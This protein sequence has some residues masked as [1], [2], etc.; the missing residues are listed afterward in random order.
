[1]G[2]KCDKQ[3][4]TVSPNGCICHC[5]G[6]PPVAVKP[7]RHALLIG[8]TSDN[9]SLTSVVANDIAGYRDALIKIGFEK[10]NI[11]SPFAGNNAVKPTKKNVLDA[12]ADAC[13]LVKKDD[14][15]LLMLTGSATNESGTLF[16]VPNDDDTDDLESSAVTIQAIFDLLKKCNT[17]YR[18]LITDLCSGGAALSE[19]KPSCPWFHATGADEFSFMSKTE[20]KRSVFSS[21]LIEG[22]SGNAANDRGQIVLKDLFDYAAPRTVKYVKDEFDKPQQPQMLG[23]VVPNFVIGT[24]K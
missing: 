7:K 14:V 15:F 18:V 16:F 19:I 3:C 21:Y 8:S 9:E 4:N 13:A 20:P 23:T 10:D 17:D 1:V 24:V 11:R 12:I 5:G 6:P 2:K 22:L